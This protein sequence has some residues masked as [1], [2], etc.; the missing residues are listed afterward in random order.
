[1]LKG[2]LLKKEHVTTNIDD[3]YVGKNE[4]PLSSSATFVISFTHFITE[5]GKFNTFN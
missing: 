1:M 2:E 4:R 3:V 5:Y